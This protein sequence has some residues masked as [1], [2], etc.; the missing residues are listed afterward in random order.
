MNK[1]LVVF[2]VFKFIKDKLLFIL[3][4]LI[5]VFVFRGVVVIWMMVVSVFC[6]VVISV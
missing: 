5:I 1:I 2:G 4:F 3:V 6:G